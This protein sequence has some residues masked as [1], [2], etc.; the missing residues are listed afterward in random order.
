M[1]EF[2]DALAFSFG[3]D[4]VDDGVVAGDEEEIAVDEL[5]EGGWTVKRKEITLF[6]GRFVGTFGHYG[7]F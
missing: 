2:V 7:F 3:V 1:E 5:L 4:D 6:R